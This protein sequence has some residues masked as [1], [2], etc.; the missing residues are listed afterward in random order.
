MGY[1]PRVLIQFEDPALRSKL[2]L[3]GMQITHE[4]YNAEY[5]VYQVY[6]EPGEAGQNLAHLRRL[7]QDMPWV[8]V[9]I[10]FSKSFR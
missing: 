3:A 8:N 7:E 10:Q 6:A 1:R 9:G 2:D 5:H 4:G